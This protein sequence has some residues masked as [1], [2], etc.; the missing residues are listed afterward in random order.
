M[1]LVSVC[2]S[3]VE[4]FRNKSSKRNHLNPV[5]HLRAEEPLIQGKEWGSVTMVTKEAGSPLTSKFRVSGGEIGFGVN[6]PVILG[7]SGAG[8]TLVSP[9]VCR[10]R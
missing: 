6:Y 5:F 7:S 3:S 2:A 8:G 4:I 1:A 10:S 9:R